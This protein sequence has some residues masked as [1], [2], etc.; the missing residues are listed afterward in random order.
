MTP[1]EHASVDRVVDA[2]PEM[3]AVLREIDNGHWLWGGA[4]S[5][6]PADDGV[7]DALRR[8]LQNRLDAVLAK[9]EGDD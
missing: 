9:I 4:D 1:A 7:D 3:L 2:V 5:E 8:E 6:D